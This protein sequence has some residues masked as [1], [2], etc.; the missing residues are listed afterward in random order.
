MDNSTVIS[1]FTAA[2]TAAAVVAAHNTDSNMPAYVHD[3][4][5]LPTAP[6]Q[7]NISINSGHETGGSAALSDDD[8]EMPELQAVT[9][10]EDSELDSDDSDNDNSDNDNSQDHNDGDTENL[11]GIS[12]I[13]ENA[14]NTRCYTV[15]NSLQSRRTVR[16]PPR[17]SCYAC[18]APVAHQGSEICPHDRGLPE[19]YAIPHDPIQ[20]G[21]MRALRL[22]LRGG[23]H[24][25]TRDSLYRYT[26]MS[27]PP[28]NQHI[29]IVPFHYYILSSLFEIDSLAKG[30]IQDF[31]LGRRE[32]AV[33][34]LAR[35]VRKLRGR[36]V[37]RV[38]I[39]P[40]LRVLPQK[41]A[42]EAR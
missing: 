16:A 42:H 17:G 38:L 40:L 27:Y 22:A 35:D 12:H 37:E 9:D 20:R 25:D 36:R 33:W 3:D 11:S 7:M 2:V 19:G 18:G 13:S 4:I 10:S 21:R 5:T 39:L 14:G 29:F 34:R 15:A 31:H 26:T 30:P 23:N 32:G 41:M 6:L 24:V 8:D 28:S 1:Y